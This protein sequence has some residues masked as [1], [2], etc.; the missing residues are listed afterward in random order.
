MDLVAPVRVVVVD[1][2]PT[3]LMSIANGL[4]LAGIPCV[5][6]WYD[7][8][9]H[10]LVPKPPVGGY[11]H[12]R[13]LFTDLNIQEM[14]GANK[15]PKTL[16]GTLI[17][18]V[19]QP[20]VSQNAG[21][22]SVV[23][24]TNV[25]GTANEVGEIISTR[26][27][28]D[29]IDEGDRRP[30][31][32][33]ITV[34]PK[35]EFTASFGDDVADKQMAG[36]FVNS[37]K[38]AIRLKEL[39]VGVTSAD[40]QLRLACAWESRA[41][42]AAMETINAVYGAAIEE[43]RSANQT[44]SDALRNIFTKIA[45]DALGGK[46]AK[47]D[48]ARALDEGLI[49]IFVDDMRSTEVNSDYAAV[50][51]AALGDAL[52]AAPQKLSASARSRLNT[53]LQI[54]HPPRTSSRIAR[55]AVLSI[56]SAEF[57]TLTSIRTQQLIWD[58][59]LSHPSLLKKQLETLKADGRSDEALQERLSFC[60]ANKKRVEDESIILVL[61]TGADCDHAQRSPRTIR[62]LCAVELPLE[63]ANFVYPKHD[64]RK[65]K[66]AALVTL[67]PWSIN[68]REV[69]LVVSVKRFVIQQDWIRVAHMEVKYRLRKPLVDL[70]L[71][72]L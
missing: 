64:Q 17:S 52:N 32:L 69:I 18:E 60:E 2:K 3:H 28:A 10:M 27:S 5:W 47:D 16:A 25:E 42:M 49:D 29:G 66:H 13:M 12:L 8:D 45:A 34:L 1:D 43:G 71:H 7:R 48:P 15:E 31:P 72:K 11:P 62:L 26:I 4:T 39:V 63:L 41:S 65:L 46:N 54:E 51:H 36:V 61:E 6:H 57:K 30:Q 14:V 9:T 40:A 21:P 37:A 56:S 19:L 24:W 68:G 22:Y 59:F 67:G 55:G 20:I 50:L 33:A 44:S 38:S 53:F 35:K 70:V 23:L 58:E